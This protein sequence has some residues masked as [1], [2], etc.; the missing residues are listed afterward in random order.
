MGAPIHSSVAF[1]AQSSGKPVIVGDDSGTI[2]R[3][4]DVN[5]LRIAVR[6]AR[7]NACQPGLHAL[8]LNNQVANHTPEVTPC[9]HR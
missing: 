3:Y 8:D 6:M 4:V 9:F 1:D 2:Q 5:E 7:C